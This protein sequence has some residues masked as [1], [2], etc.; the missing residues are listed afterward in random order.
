MYL[1]ANLELVASLS[2]TDFLMVALAVDGRLAGVFESD[3]KEG[4][5]EADLVA[6]RKVDDLPVSRINN[7]SLSDVNSHQHEVYAI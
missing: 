6:D 5:E 2:L 1:V 7:V 3:A 4:F